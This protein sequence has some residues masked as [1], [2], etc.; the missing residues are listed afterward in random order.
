MKPLAEGFM[1]CGFYSQGLSH[2]P[3]HKAQH[4]SP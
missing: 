1:A 3:L 2:Q 4:L